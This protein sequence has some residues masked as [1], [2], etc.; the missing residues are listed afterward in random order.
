MYA[1]PRLSRSFPHSPLTI[2]PHPFSLFV[3]HLSSVILPLPPTLSPPSLHCVNEDLPV[4]SP[5][6]QSNE[7]CLKQVRPCARRSRL[8][9]NCPS[10]AWQSII[11]QFRIIKKTPLQSQRCLFNIIIKISYSLSPPKCS[12]C[13]LYRPCRL[14]TYEPQ[15]SHELK[16]PLPGN[17]YSQ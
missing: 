1:P 13:K 11:L 4:A 14:R 5:S 17:L 7:P 2:Y 9:W 8:R 15:T 12:A 10:G 16:S 6:A 3:F